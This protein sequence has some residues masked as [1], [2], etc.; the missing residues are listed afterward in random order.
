M[1]VWF[2]LRKPTAHHNFVQVQLMG[3]DVTEERYKA[4]LAPIAEITISI[5]N[6]RWI[7]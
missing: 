5:D 2:A 1:I 3:D 4:V 7:R 6:R